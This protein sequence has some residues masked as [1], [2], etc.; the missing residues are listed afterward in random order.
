MQHYSGGKRQDDITAVDFATNHER[1]F[2]KSSTA[3]VYHAFLS[4]DDR[5]VAFKKKLG[6]TEAQI[7]IAPVREGRAT[8]E[9]DWIAVTDGHFG[10]DKRQFTGWR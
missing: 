3:E 2:L 1:E 8:G 7:M 9:S 6:T 10:D 5:C 4:W